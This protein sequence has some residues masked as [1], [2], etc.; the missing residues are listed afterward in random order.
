M[1]PYSVLSPLA[2]E[3]SAHVTISKTLFRFLISEYL[4]SLPFDEK[5][6]LETNPDVDAAVHRGELK[7]GEEHFLYTG[8]FEGRETGSTEFDEKWYLKNNPDVVASV[9]RGDW[10]TGKEHWL[11]M[12][13]AELRA[14]SRALVPLYDTWRQFLLNNKYK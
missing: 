10:T 6:Y 5:A 8:F 7:S 12:G 13:R 9:R 4:K 11:A 14:P 2:E 1:I 3:S